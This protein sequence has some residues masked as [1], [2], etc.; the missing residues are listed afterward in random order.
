MTRGSYSDLSTFYET[1]DSILSADQVNSH[2]IES[3]A[4]VVG[5]RISDMKD[6]LST[7]TASDLESLSSLFPPHRVSDF[8]AIPVSE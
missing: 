5:D 7:V 4:R 8:D 3:L 6:Q 1:N 2:R